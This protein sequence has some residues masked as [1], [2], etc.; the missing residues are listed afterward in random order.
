MTPLLI[1]CIMIFTSAHAHADSKS[2]I[3]NEWHA[4]LPYTPMPDIIK[5]LIKTDGNG[6][7]LAS[8]FPNPFNVRANVAGYFIWHNVSVDDVRH[9]FLKKD[10]KLGAVMKEVTLARTISGNTFLPREESDSIP[11]SSAKLGQILDRLAVVPG[12]T[13]AKHIE[14]TLRDCESPYSKGKTKFCATSLE[15]MIDFV[16]SELR[17]RDLKVIATTVHGKDEQQETTYKMAAEGKELPGD[18]LVAC[19]PQPYPYTIY[20]CHVN[21]AAKAY[22]VPLVRKDGVKVSTAVVCHF[23]TSN[24]K[25]I[26][27]QVLKVKPGTKPAICHFVPQDHLL[28][29]PNK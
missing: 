13:T 3:W 26:F 14:N 16:T 22:V 27:F 2:S 17:T 5:D 1:F 20:Y 12:S 4:M 10:M 24:W 6:H 8:K 11:F 15:S 29:T 25:P 21:K 23:D 18:K 9:L 19:H 7:M 28:W